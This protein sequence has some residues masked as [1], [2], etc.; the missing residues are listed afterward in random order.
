MT[1]FTWWLVDLASRALEPL[2]RDVVL[3]DVVESGETATTALFGVLGL[4]ARRSAAMWKEWRPWLVLAGLAIPLGIIFHWVSKRI[5]YR[6]AIYFWLYANNWDW[7]H[8]EPGFRQ[9]LAHYGAAILIE[10]AI[11]FWLSWSGGFI[12][13]SV[14]RRS[15]PLQLLSFGFVLFFAGSL[16]WPSQDFTGKLLTARH[17]SVNAAVFT[18]PFYREMLPV[19]LQLSL[20]V[21]PA[22]WA[23]HG[24]RGVS[25]RRPSP[26]I[27]TAIAALAAM[28]MQIA[29]KPGF[30]LRTV[31]Y[32]SAVYSLGMALGARF[33]A[34]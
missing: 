32:T 31:V 23:A 8:L 2:E 3:G 11:L 10:Y 25:G 24:R 18:S 15:L 6:S 1:R 14:A 19:L 29:S 34:T 13:G 7:T 26:G 27:T 12:L 17:F 4:V 5:A 9:D 28:T 30:F 22:A 16:S 21:L 33:L 20:V